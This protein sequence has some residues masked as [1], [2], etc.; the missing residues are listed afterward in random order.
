MSKAQETQ[1]IGYFSPG[2]EPLVTD[3]LNGVFQLFNGTIYNAKT[4]WTL[5]SRRL[6]F[7]H[8]CHRKKLVGLFCI[9][10][11]G[12]EPILHKKLQYTM[13]MY[14]F[15]LSSGA[16]IQGT[17]IRSSTIKDYLLAAATLI[18]RFDVLG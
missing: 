3:L 1:I 15:E 5:R 16:S 6:H 8:F 17:K 9:R 14:A 13:A 18:S 4:A 12:E 2:Q 7:I 10:K 11:Q